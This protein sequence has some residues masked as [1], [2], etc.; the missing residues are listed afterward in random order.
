[1]V[2]IG[3]NSETDHCSCMLHEQNIIISIYDSIHH[4]VWSLLCG[5][6]L[7]VT[8]QHTE[9]NSLM[10]YQQARVWQDPGWHTVKVKAHRASGASSTNRKPRHNRI[11]HKF[12]LMS[13]KHPS[14]TAAASLLKQH[15]TKYETHCASNFHRAT[16]RISAVPQLEPHRPHAN[17]EGQQEVKNCKTVLTPDWPSQRRPVSLNPDLGEP[18]SERLWHVR[19]HCAWVKLTG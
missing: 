15:R 1:M 7:G 17:S 6:S 10:D 19:A 12:L 2:K 9:I 4:P 18:C 8:L 13:W 16:C 3:Q 5:F 14:S 11:I